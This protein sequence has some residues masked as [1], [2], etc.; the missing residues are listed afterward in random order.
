MIDQ[1]E[2]SHRAENLSSC[3]Y[4]AFCAYTAATHHSAMMFRIGGREEATDLSSITL[5]VIIM[6]MATM[7]PSP[8]ISWS[9]LTPNKAVCLFSQQILV[10]S[11]KCEALL[12]FW[13]TPHRR[14]PT[15]HLRHP[16]ILVFD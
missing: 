11:T 14:L 2:K 15:I 3:S 8:K 13:T 16:I 9:L 7:F 10:M 4:S 12:E 6:T 5:K 1:C